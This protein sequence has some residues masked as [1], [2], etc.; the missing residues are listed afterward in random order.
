MSDATSVESGRHNAG[1]QV[2]STEGNQTGVQ[3]PRTINTTMF[4]EYHKGV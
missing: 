3:L 2:H 1:T 4:G